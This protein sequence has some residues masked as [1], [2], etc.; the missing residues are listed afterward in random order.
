MESNPNNPNTPV[1]QHSSTPGSS[2]VRDILSA[3]FTSLTAA[4]VDEARLKA[5]YV[6][7]HTLKCKRL[8]LALRGE[9]ELTPEQ[10]SETDA[11]AA[12]LIQGEPLQYVLGET[13]FMGR[14]FTT[15]RRALIPRPETEELV[16]HVLDCEEIW[17]GEH[18]RVIDVGTGTGCIAITFALARPHADV[19]ATDLS[20]PALALA[21]ENALRH[22]VERRVRFEKADLLGDIAPGSCDAVVSNP[23]YIKESEMV[24]LPLDVRCFEPRE[25]LAAGV[26][27]LE[28]ISGLVP[29]AYRALKSGG[30]LYMEIAE[31]QGAPVRALMKRTAFENVEIRRDLTGMER[32][33]C[34][35]KG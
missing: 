33:A 9:E 20:E 27:G 17:C 12:R 13:E 2:S 21:R 11:F 3:I 31:D 10:N 1:L 14:L 15:D 16:Q 29:A 24:S 22:G 25:A 7:A 35:R 8:E 19:C 30:W 32:F 34:G 4:G 28:V 5:E 26:D 6:M 18:P 23:P